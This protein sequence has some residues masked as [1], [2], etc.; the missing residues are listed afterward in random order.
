MY[1]DIVGDNLSHA[2]AFSYRSRHYAW[3][4]ESCVRVLW[5]TGMQNL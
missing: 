5:W 3:Q 4:K 1:A 2:E